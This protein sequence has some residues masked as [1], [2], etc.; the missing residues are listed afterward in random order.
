MATTTA[1][2]ST[3]L[4]IVFPPTETANVATSPNT[5]DSSTEITASPVAVEVEKR[6]QEAD[7][8][9]NILMIGAIAVEAEN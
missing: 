6:V 4:S 3:W 5:G 1:G 9:W 2:P 8:I 7:G